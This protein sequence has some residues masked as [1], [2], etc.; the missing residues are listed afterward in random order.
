MRNFM[1]TLVLCFFAASLSV[2]QEKT[3]SGKTWELYETD[4]PEDSV[5]QVKDWKDKNKFK[6]SFYQEREMF[7]PAAIDKERGFAYFVK[8]TTD[9][10]YPA[11]TPHKD[12]LKAGVCSFG[13]AG[14][15][16]FA[17]FL[18]YP[19]QD[20]KSIKVEAGDLEGPGGKLIPAG[21]IEISSV[22]YDFDPD[23]TGG[24]ILR[25]KHV[26]LGVN[27]APG[28]KEAPR[29]FWLRVKIPEDAPGGVYKG[30]LTVSG[31]L[32]PAGVEIS[33]EVFPFKIEKPGEAYFFGP[34]TYT[35]ADVYD[36]TMEKICED[37]AKHDM[38]VMHGGLG[39]AL[40]IDAAYGTTFDFSKMDKNA[41]I[42]KKY[43]IN[44]WIIEMTGLPNRFVDTLRCRYYD[45][46][47][48]NAYVSMLM[49]L[50]DRMVKK[51]W[52]EILI[53]YDEPREYD[54]DNKRPLAR[55]YF[56]IENLL[57]LHKQAKLAA[58]PT[59]MRDSG[60]KRAENKTQEANYYELCRVS[61]FN[62]T[63]GWDQAAKIMKETLNSGNTLYLY[64]CGGYGRFQ[65]GLLTYRYG[66]KGNMQ[67]WYTSGPGLS[68]ASQFPLT[69]AVSTCGLFE[70][71]YTPVIRYLRSV[72]GVHDFWYLVMLEQALKNI[73]NK[74]SLDA[75]KA[76]QLLGKIKQL[77]VKKS[78][79]DERSA[80]ILNP[81]TLKDFPGTRFD[82]YKYK[83][84]QLIIKL[85]QEAAN[86]SDK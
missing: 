12:E 7:L 46:T 34:F 77:D 45:N 26:M 19:L 44:K 61:K 33:V 54:S 43:G 81:E 51:K 47:F 18:V 56:D 5:L 37:L 66:A 49:K 3:N 21:N 84:A 28:L 78:G 15:K 82:E 30:S 36:K 2:A 20:I 59:F 67:F 16:V 80:D 10:I 68:T 53:M 32:K 4:M 9:D 27:E 50:K 73:K 79:A 52:P 8:P 22:K 35:N 39:N 38:N 71:S 1:L 11:M 14:E 60:G 25:A 64:N 63:H 31:G 72:E 29:P 76:E 69:Y 83:A 65:F 6:E 23:G 55:T 24:W 48:N 13:A 17:L 86:T 58:I 70:G 40:K 57:K 74:T 62:M 85:R 75:I 42:M 41:E